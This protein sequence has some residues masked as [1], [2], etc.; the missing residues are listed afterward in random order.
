MPMAVIH[1]AERIGVDPFLEMWRVLDGDMWFRDWRNG[2]EAVCL[3]LWR[4]R[5][6]ER[7]QRNRY[8]ETLIDAGMGYAQVA[9]AVRARMGEKM[10]PGNVRKVSKRAKMRREEGQP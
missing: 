7:Y 3:R 2:Y 9:E 6:Y 4:Y 8:I 10:T 1:L 5:W